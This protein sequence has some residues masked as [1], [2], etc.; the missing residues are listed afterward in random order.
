MSFTV[1]RIAEKEKASFRRLE[2]DRVFFEI[3]TS[4]QASRFGS[5]SFF[6][7]L[8][9]ELGAEVCCLNGWCPTCDYPHTCDTTCEELGY[10][11]WCEKEPEVCPDE[12]AHFLD[13]GCGVYTEC[14]GLCS[15]TGD[16]PMH[17]ELFDKDADG[18]VWY[19][20][21]EPDLCTWDDPPGSGTSAQGLQACMGA[22]A[23]CAAP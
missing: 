5:G 6:S 7:S 2:T 18:C 23:P 15:A 13:D 14:P 9:G 17:N 22:C 11:P 20:G 4:R 1:A 21:V 8:A 3:F 10:A 19:S 12:C 16:N